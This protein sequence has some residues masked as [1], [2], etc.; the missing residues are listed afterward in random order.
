MKSDNTKDQ[1]LEQEQTWLDPDSLLGVFRNIVVAQLLLVFESDSMDP[2]EIEQYLKDFKGY[3]EWREKGGSIRL[4][5]FEKRNNSAQRKKSP[6]FLI[7]DEARKYFEER[8]LLRELTKV[9][10]QRREELYNR[11]Q[12]KIERTVKNIVC[13]IDKITEPGDIANELYLRL[14]ENDSAVLR[15]IAPDASLEAYICRTARNLCYELIKGP[16]PVISVDDEDMK[17]VWERILSTFT[18]EDY[19][20][21]NSKEEDIM[22]VLM[23]TI[24]D[25]KTLSSNE[26][27]VMIDHYLHGKPYIEIAAELQTSVLNVTNNIAKRAKQKVQKQIRKVIDNIDNEEY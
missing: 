22:E 6:S 4:K 10:P 5:K 9:P 3:M 14:L 1:T 19:C 24:N 8:L 16:D 2:D 21:F 26:K 23:Q 20:F 17:D 12:S 13:D 27:K 15:A 7:K 18:E 11:Y 25:D